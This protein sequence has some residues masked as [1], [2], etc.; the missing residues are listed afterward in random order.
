MA[1]EAARLL[2]GWDTATASGRPVDLHRQMTAY[3]MRVLGRLL[4]GSDIDGAIAEVA[5]A[6]PVIN[7]HVR[8]HVLA[9]LRA[10]RDWPTPANRRAARARRSLDRVVDRIIQ[11]RRV[12]ASGADDLI[13]R[14]PPLRL[15]AL[16]RRPTPASVPPSRCWRRCWLRRS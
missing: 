7:G 6:F 11:Q 12:Q 14:L 13:G 2:Q 3:T 4:L 8:R 15:P 10:P 9:P 5:A 16:W 1:E